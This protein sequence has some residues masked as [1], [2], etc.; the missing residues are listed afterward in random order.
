MSDCKGVLALILQRI[1]SCADVGLGGIDGCLGGG[2]EGER[3]VCV[4][5]KQLC[6]QTNDY[7][8]RVCLIYGHTRSVLAPGSV[9]RTDR[10]Q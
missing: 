7:L 4:S 10:M 6:F 2:L 3:H 1:Y 5:W 8:C 9:D